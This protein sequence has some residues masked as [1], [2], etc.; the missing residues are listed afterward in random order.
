MRN[1]VNP[2]IY[3]PYKNFSRNKFLTQDFNLKEVQQFVKVK[4]KLNKHWLL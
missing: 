4:I 1:Y 2:E 3:R